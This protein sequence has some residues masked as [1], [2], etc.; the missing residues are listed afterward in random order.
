[1]GVASPYMGVDDIRWF[2]KQLSSLENYLALNKQLY[3]YVLEAD[4]RDYGTEYEVPVGSCDWTTPVKY[5]ED[6]CELITAP[7]KQYHLMEGCG[8]APQYDRPEEFCKILRSMLD[9]YVQ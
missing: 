2:I 6:Y 7:Q 9:E 3:D 5:A 1:M 4:V 8:H